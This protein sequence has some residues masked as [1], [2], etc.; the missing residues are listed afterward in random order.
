[1]NGL[2]EWTV[3]FYLAG[4][5]ELSSFIVP[6]LKAIKDA[7]FQE[8]VNVL[9]YSDPNVRGA[10]T[11]IF[12]VNRRRKQRLIDQMKPPTRI[13]DGNDPFVRNLIEDDIA[14]TIN[15]SAPISVAL[16]GEISAV[17]SLRGFLRFCRDTHPAKHYILFT[18]G[19]GMIVGNDA[20]LPDSNPVTAI[21]L[22][23]LEEILREFPRKEA[24]DE[25]EASEES[26]LELLALHSCSL[27]AIEVAYQLKGAANFMMASE[28][29]SFVEGWPYRQLLKKIFNTVDKAKNKKVNV[30]ELVGDLYYLAYFNATDYLLSGFSLDLA[31]CDLSTDTVEAIKPSLQTLVSRLKAGLKDKRIQ[32]LILLAHWKSQSYW[33]ENYTDLFDF[34][35]CLALACDTTN[36]QQDLVRTA[37]VNVM[38]AINRI[39]ILSETFGWEYQYSH[40]L[41]IYFP[42]SEPLDEDFVPDSS[43]N[44]LIAQDRKEDRT[45]TI[46][47]NYRDYTF[48]TDFEGDSWLSFLESYFV[49][50][51][52]PS[53]EEEDGTTR[54]EDESA[55][56]LSAVALSSALL[57]SALPGPDDPG[58]TT[59]TTGTACAC[60]SIKNYPTTVVILK[61]GK[62]RTVTEPF[63]TRGTLRAF[64]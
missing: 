17:E 58:K 49:E 18:V 52:R 44:D 38:E 40:G 9:V 39:V 50:T 42:W 23:E 55:E 26:T 2:S 63:I 56:V 54:N 43:R 11:R 57:D 8:D 60:P 33:Q 10:R 21:T 13:G 12:N 5:N 31:L 29:I 64:E 41:S 7:G 6:Q 59:G 51:K 30:R 16:N 36:E 22:K 27:S 47:G 4:D 15:P 35:R 24:S 62:R 46:L 37:C 25:S 19:H 34:C 45:M 28:G 53:R 1:M 32:E 14:G 61:D 20:F 3:M 48:T